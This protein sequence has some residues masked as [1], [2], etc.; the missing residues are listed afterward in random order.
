MLWQKENSGPIAF[1][2][3]EAN[4]LTRYLTTRVVLDS[5]LILMK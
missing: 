1:Y 4:Y 3:I 2:E 5:F